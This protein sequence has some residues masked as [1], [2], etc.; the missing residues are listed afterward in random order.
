MVSNSL[1]F[2]GFLLLMI[3][4]LYVVYWVYTDA[5]A[6]GNAQLPWAIFVL[7]TTAFGLLIYLLFRNSSTPRY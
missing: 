5:K 3:G 2:I 4:L 1:S 7:F 6:R